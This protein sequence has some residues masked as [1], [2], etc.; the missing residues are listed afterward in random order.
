MSVT[1]TQHIPGSGLAR[2]SPGNFLEY[3]LSPMA[4]AAH[5]ARFDFV[6]EHRQLLQITNGNVPEFRWFMNRPPAPDEPGFP[7][8]VP[9]GVVDVYVVGLSFA[10]CPVYRLQVTQLPNGV[11]L[12]DLSFQAQSP[13]DRWSEP[14]AVIHS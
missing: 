5:V 2:L 3:S 9:A 7:P 4:G 10:N 13:A 1:V 11:L 14:L 8:D 12:K 6:C